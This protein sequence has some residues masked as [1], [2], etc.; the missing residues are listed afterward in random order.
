MLLPLSVL[1]YAS[2]IG[3]FSLLAIIGIILFDGFAKPDSPGSL[4]SPA[5]TSL[6]IDNY[7]ELGIAFGLFMAGV[8]SSTSLALRGTLT[9]SLVQQFAGHA[10]IPTLAKDMIDPSRFDEMIDWAFVIATG[11]YGLL[12]VTGYIMFGNAVSDEVCCIVATSG[13]A[14]AEHMHSSAWIS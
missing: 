11:I 14:L 12:G 7:R 13:R 6:G 1:S 2:I 9:S 3:I 10:I 5:E 8:R 4:W